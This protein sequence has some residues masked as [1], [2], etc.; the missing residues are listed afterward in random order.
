MNISQEVIWVEQ[1]I[2]RHIIPPVHPLLLSERVHACRL[3]KLNTQ[4][5]TEQKKSFLSLL[6]T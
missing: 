6:N 4:G 5:L 3:F 2:L 1:I